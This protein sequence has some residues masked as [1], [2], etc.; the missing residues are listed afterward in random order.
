MDPF[1][2]AADVE[3]RW[4]EL[5]EEERGRA[6]VLLAD[7]AAL[8]RSL[9]SRAGVEVDPEDEVQAANL[10]AVS[11]S[12]VQRAMGVGEE[13]AGV[14]QYSQTAG[15]YSWSA[16]AANPNGDLY[17]TKTEQQRL[18]LKRMRAGSI[19]PTIGVAD[20]TW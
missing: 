14:S 15:P 20:D 4:R 17:L 12:M 2:S 13:S 1:A 19:R 6:D 16:T 18:G 10:E 11:C 5:A 3:A 8:L 9:L 7:A